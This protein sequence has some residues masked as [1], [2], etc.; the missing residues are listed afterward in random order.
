MENNFK[1]TQGECSVS[2]YSNQAATIVTTPDTNICNVF[3]GGTEECNANAELIVD[4][5]NVRQKIN[6]SL[7]ELLN[8]Y[9]SKESA[10]KILKGIFE[11]E[12]MIDAGQCR[13]IINEALNK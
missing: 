9:N 12:S 1:G 4:A 8:D 5:F 13:R 6:C 11:G 10:L 3:K 7:P 2:E